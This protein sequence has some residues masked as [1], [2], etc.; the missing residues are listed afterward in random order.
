MAVI[1][2]VIRLEADGT[3]SFGNYAVPG[4][5]KADGFEADGAVYNVRTHKEITRLERNGTLLFEA[6]P[7]AAVH[8]FK[9]DEAGVSFHLEGVVDTKITLELA[10]DREYAIRI[11]GETV[12]SAK[13]NVSGKVSFSVDL[14]AAPQAVRVEGL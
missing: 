4:K 13:S 10:P 8:H 7:G 3:V 9:T 14:H 12:G 2:E 1:D 5:Q 6:V 11:G